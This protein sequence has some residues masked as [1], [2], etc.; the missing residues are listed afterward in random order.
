MNINITPVLCN[1]KNMQNYAYIVH[2]PKTNTTI[3][4]DAAEATPIIKKLEE[5]N[6]TP[7][8]I[9]TT[10]HHFDHVEGNTNLKEKYNLQIIAPINEFDKVPS[11]DIKAIDNTPIIINDIT[12]TPIPAPGHTLGHM[13]YHIKEINALF[14]GDVLFNLCIGGLFEGT[15]QQMFSSLQKIK[16]LPL[17]TIIYPGHEYTRACLSPNLLSLPNFD[18]YIQKMLSREQGNFIF[19]TLKEELS[20]NPYLQASTLKDFIG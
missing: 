9:L 16:N 6:L 11:A 2:S 14:T 20:F 7:S 3:I 13:L 10:H 15:A 8:H 17:D 4:I 1:E 19:S 18:T 5:L 12:I